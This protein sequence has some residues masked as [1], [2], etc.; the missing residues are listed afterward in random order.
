[1]VAE[2]L[3]L[4]VSGPPGRG[5]DPGRATLTVELERGSRRTSRRP[6]RRPELTNRPAGRHVVGLGRDLHGGPLTWFNPCSPDARR[7]KAETVADG[8]DHAARTLMPFT[9]PATWWWRAL[10]PQSRP[11]ERDRHQRRGLAHWTPLIASNF[12]TRIATRL[13]G[14]AD[15]PNCR[16]RCVVFAD[17]RK[18]FSANG[19][20][21]SPP[22][23]QSQMAAARTLRSRRCPTGAVRAGRRTRRRAWLIAELTSAVVSVY[24]RYL[25][26]CGMSWPIYPISIAQ[27]AEQ[28]SARPRPDHVRWHARGGIR[29]RGLGQ[30]RYTTCFLSVHRSRSRRVRRSLSRPF[31]SNWSVNPVSGQGWRGQ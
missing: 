9:V 19:G 10:M 13:L 4:G 23:G 14:P 28:R 24:G 16:C 11:V 25:K 3:R 7:T 29:S 30:N 26:L 17:R 5:V 21:A 2:I 1:M 20:L 27:Q 15:A 31:S 18:S 12:V 8:P 22:H 6:G